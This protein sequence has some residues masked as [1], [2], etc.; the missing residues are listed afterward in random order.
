MQIINSPNN[1]SSQVNDF[2][3]RG[4]NSEGGSGL[5]NQLGERVSQTL[6][7]MS[8]P[9]AGNNEQTINPQQVVQ[10][11]AQM[12]DKPVAGMNHSVVV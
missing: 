1:S 5:L 2:Q 7:Q 3:P 11:I 6:A 8:G 9:T 12:T 10:T 4:L